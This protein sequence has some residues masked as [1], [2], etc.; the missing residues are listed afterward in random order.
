MCAL[1]EQSSGQMAR[2]LPGRI[3]G[4]VLSEKDVWPVSKG[5]SDIWSK[6]GW[7]DLLEYCDSSL[8]LILSFFEG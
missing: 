5:E 2:V 6:I 1:L 7:V 4:D 3:S 8:S